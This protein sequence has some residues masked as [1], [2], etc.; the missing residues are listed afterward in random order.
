LCNAR[1]IETMAARIVFIGQIGWLPK[2][3]K[4]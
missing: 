3:A 2:Y 1:W 4:P